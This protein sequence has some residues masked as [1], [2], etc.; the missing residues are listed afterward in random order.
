MGV[1]EESGI[2]TGNPFTQAL[3]PE[4]RRRIDHEVPF[5]CPYQKGGARAMVAGIGGAADRAVT[6]D[7]RHPLG[8][9]GTEKSQIQR[10]HGEKS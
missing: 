3:D 2:K 6:A 10:R 4:I 9:P 5:G 1:S 8:S 7:D